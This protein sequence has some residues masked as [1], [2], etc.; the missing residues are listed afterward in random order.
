MR[1]SWPLLTNRAKHRTGCL[2]HKTG[3]GSAAAA[4]GAHRTSIDQRS[5]SIENAFRSSRASGTRR[6]V[7]SAFRQ[8]GASGTR[9]S[10]GSLSGHRGSLGDR[11]RSSGSVS[12]PSKRSN[13]GASG[14][15]RTGSGAP[16]SGQGCE[17]TLPEGEILGR[18]QKV[19]LLT[20]LLQ[21]TV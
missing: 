16:K 6:S 4:T 1:E 9:G 11:R 8:G 3:V 10:M 7:G 18:K 12:S 13:R 20:I 5:A 14:G 21:F 15:A 19:I 2:D 17:D